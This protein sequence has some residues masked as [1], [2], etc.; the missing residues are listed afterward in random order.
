MPYC[1]LLNAFSATKKLH[2]E[3]KALTCSVHFNK[4]DD[5]SALVIL[6]C[7]QKPFHASVPASMRGTFESL[8]Y[9]RYSQLRLLRIRIIRI[10]VQFVCI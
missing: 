8:N 10:F 3:M 4:P 1:R 7:I 5:G 6:D 9:Q 2:V